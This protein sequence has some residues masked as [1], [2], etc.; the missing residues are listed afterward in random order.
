M[1]DDI[2][3]RNFFE[4]FDVPACFDID[5]EQVQSRYTALQS[6]VHPDRFASGSDAEKRLAMQQASHINEALQTLRNP[7]LRAAC[8]LKLKGM[9]I[10]LDNETTMDA[11]FLMQQLELRESMATLRSGIES[12]QG[13]DEADALLAKLDGMTGALRENSQQIMRAFDDCYRHDRLDEAREWLRKMQFL[14]KAT[15]EAAGL[16]ELLED[17]ML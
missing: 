13:D 5:M 9:D 16:S 17:K 14:Q 3:N 8:L 1:T 11:A 4:L 10:D 12:V 2:L 7:V 15:R 6:I